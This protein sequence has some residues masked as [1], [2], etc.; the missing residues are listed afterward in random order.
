V[1]TYSVETFSPLLG[2]EFLIRGSDNATVPIVLVQADSLA[3]ERAN[4]TAAVRQPF[5]LLFRGPLSPELSQGMYP[6]E[7]TALE[8]NLYFLVPVERKDDGMYYE[9]VFN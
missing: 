6:M 3:N 4:N 8:P 1:D 9:A 5:S 7:H 2:E